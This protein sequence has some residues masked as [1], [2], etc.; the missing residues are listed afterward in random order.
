MSMAG[1]TSLA[2]T[3]VIVA[4]SLLVGGIWLGD[5]SSMAEDNKVKLQSVQTITTDQAVIKEKIKNINRQLESQATTLQTI[6]AA[7]RNGNRS[8]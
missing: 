7:I 6:L 2:A 1:A 5:V 8:P 4:S 3:I